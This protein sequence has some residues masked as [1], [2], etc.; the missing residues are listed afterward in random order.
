MIRV[1]SFVDTLAIGLVIF[2]AAS[3]MPATSWSQEELPGPDIDGAAK[4]EAQENPAPRLDEAAE[5]KELLGM[6]ESRRD[7][8][9]K[10][11]A[12]QQARLDLPG[13]GDSQRRVSMRDSGSSAK[14]RPRGRLPRIQMDASAERRTNSPLLSAAAAGA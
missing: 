11:A 4:A 6:L 1:S 7:T 2:F 10:R 14:P 13:D 5:P 8:L 12:I 9:R 3:A